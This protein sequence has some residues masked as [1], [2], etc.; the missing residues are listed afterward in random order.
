M[1]PRLPQ[2]SSA[3]SK[4]VERDP[5]IAANAVNSLH[6]QLFHLQPLAQS[7]HMERRTTDQALSCSG[8]P[9]FSSLFGRR[10]L[11]HLVLMPKIVHL[12]DFAAD[13]EQERRVVR[14]ED[15]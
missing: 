15:D 9:E 11:R 3:S 4:I 10:L 14:P 5:K 2:A 1:S 12:R 7:F 6:S 8:L 13:Q